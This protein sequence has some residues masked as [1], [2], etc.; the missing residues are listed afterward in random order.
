[1]QRSSKKSD[2]YLIQGPRKSRFP[3]NLTDR[4]T[5]GWTDIGIYRVASLLIRVKKVYLEQQSSL[6]HIQFLTDKHNELQRSFATKREVSVIANVTRT[7]IQVIPQGTTQGQTVQQD[8][9]FQISAIADNKPF[10]CTTIILLCLHDNKIH[11]F[12]VKTFPPTFPIVNVIQL[13]Q[14]Q[15]L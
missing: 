14:Q 5:Y 6:S 7:Y 13:T 12:W 10:D 8:Q 15:N 11:L 1:M 9:R 3:L 2:L 4:Q